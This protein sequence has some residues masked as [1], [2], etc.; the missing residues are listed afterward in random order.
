[1]KGDPYLLHLSQCVKAP[2]P[3][4][5]GVAAVIYQGWKKHSGIGIRSLWYSNI[6]AVKNRNFAN[7][8][9]FN[10]QLQESASAN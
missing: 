8:C 5:L 3:R 6:D 7:F 10:S 1:M 9:N 4:L 2:N